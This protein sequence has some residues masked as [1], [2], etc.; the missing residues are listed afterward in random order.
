[1]K[2]FSM[3]DRNGDGE[4]KLTIRELFKMLDLS[5]NEADAISDLHI[6][7]QVRLEPDEIYV[8]READG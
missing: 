7:G 5:D 6:K 8:T 3:I 2:L 1:M 4:P